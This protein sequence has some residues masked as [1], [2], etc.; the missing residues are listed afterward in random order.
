MATAQSEY[1][2][3]RLLLVTVNEDLEYLRQAQQVTPT[4]H[5]LASTIQFKERMRVAYMALVEECR[6]KL[7]GDQSDS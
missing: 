2:A 6:L 3:A 1:D 5:R 7:E 4:D